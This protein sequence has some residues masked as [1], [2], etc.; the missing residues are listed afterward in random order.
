[1]LLTIL[2]TSKI[3]NVHNQAL[4]NYKNSK[5]KVFLIKKK[6]SKKNKKSISD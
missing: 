1:M 5:F 2:L 3:D 6:N 4:E